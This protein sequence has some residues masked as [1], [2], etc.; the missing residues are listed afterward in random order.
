VFL[1]RKKPVT[2]IEKTPFYDK[3]ATLGRALFYKIIRPLSKIGKN[4]F[5]G[6][7]VY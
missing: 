2:F 7:G 4:Y 1:I 6:F 5:S 3:G